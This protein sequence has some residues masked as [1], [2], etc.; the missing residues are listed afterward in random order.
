MSFIPYNAGTKTII[1]GD[2]CSQLINFK[3]NGIVQNTTGWKFYYTLKTDL[4]DVTD[5]SSALIKK[6][7]NGL[8]YD[9]VDLSL[10]KDETKLAPGKYK[11]DIQVKTNLNIVLTLV[12]GKIK[13]KKSVTN[14]DN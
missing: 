9:L 14:R 12:Q 1:A 10:T 8:N 6:E 11:Y 2:T 5:D 13:I 7:A 4:D 3:V